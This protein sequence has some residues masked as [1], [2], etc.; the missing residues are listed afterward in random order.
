[1]VE[2]AN[3]SQGLS[4]K[5]IF[6]LTC[7]LCQIHDT[8]EK[9]RDCEESFLLFLL[10]PAL[11]GVFCFPFPRSQSMSNH[12]ARRTGT[13]LLFSNLCESLPMYPF[14]SL[15]C[16]QISGLPDVQNSFRRDW[17]LGKRLALEGDF[18]YC[19]PINKRERECENSRN[20]R[21]HKKRRVWDICVYI[22]ACVALASRRGR[23]TSS[24]PCVS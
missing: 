23:V 19:I 17:L 16:S 14:L 24:T 21:K 9:A 18:S 15:I 6:M 8:Q 2:R 1:V 10:F 13:C 11:T 7:F 5:S 20:K 22:H 3:R 4:P 12:L